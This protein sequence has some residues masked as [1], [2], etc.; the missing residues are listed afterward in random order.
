[1]IRLVAVIVVMTIMLTDGFVSSSRS[2]GKSDV[3]ASKFDEGEVGGDILSQSMFNLAE[4]L[5]QLV[6][7][8]REVGIGMENG[9]SRV[10][11]ELS[12]KIAAEMIRAE[13]EAAFWTTGDMDYN[14]WEDGA[15]F[16]DPFSSF[17]GMGHDKNII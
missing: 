17:E 10:P 3:S 4:G 11:D 5:S 9:R 6:R 13:H 12:T 14:L 7:K 8:E 2:I 16:T 15:T 1:M